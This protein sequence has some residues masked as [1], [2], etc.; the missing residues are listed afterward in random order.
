V[1]TKYFPTKQKAQAV[2]ETIDK[3][4][5]VN[6]FQMEGEC[7]E[8]KVL[9]FRGPRNSPWQKPKFAIQL[10]DCGEYLKCTGVSQ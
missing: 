8:S 6:R 5:C 4:L 2:A 9:E 3:T 7:Q 10:G 1:K